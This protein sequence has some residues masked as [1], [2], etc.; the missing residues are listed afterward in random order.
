[1]RSVRAT[2]PEVERLYVETGKVLLVHVDL[3]LKIHR[4]AF[5]AA[6]AAECA[7]EQDKFWEYRWHLFAHQSDLSEPKLGEY[8]GEVGLERAPF[9]ECLAS[10]RHAKEIRKDV[11]E[12]EKAGVRGTPTFFI[13]RRKPGTDKVKVLETIR[14]PAPFEDFQEALDR[15]LSDD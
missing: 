7:A 15:H 6:E 5:R 8:A 10:G 2:L 4:D 3:P 13:G 14:G 11:R 9:D 12:A 1:M